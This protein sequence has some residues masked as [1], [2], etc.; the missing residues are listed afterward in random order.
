MNVWV[1]W[2][3]Y[4]LVINEMLSPGRPSNMYAS[5]LYLGGCATKDKSCRMVK[6]FFKQMYKF[7]FANLRLHSSSRS[8]AKDMCNAVLKA[9]GYGS[10]PFPCNGRYPKERYFQV[11]LVPLQKYGTLEF[12]AHSATYDAERV[13]RWVQFLIAFVERFGTGESSWSKPYFSAGSWE[14]GYESLRQDQLSARSKELFAALDGKIDKNTKSYY[15]SR[16]W[17]KENPTCKHDEVLKQS[18]TFNRALW[19]GYHHC[20]CHGSLCKWFSEAH[21][22][23][24][25]C[26]QVKLADGQPQCITRTPICFLDK[27]CEQL[28]SSTRCRAPKSDDFFTGTYC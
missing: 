10:N 9:D 6:G 7:R 5:P 25:K 14:E 16:A 8:G 15:A 4:Q 20:C 28:Q 18:M 23:D 3:K 21:S 2:A 22:P 24:G 17:E 27:S 11:N 13:A 26:P 1:A 12:R 19:K